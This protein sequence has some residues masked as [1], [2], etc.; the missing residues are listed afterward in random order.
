M[1]EVAFLYQLLKDCA[2]EFLDVDG[3]FP[4]EVHLR[5]SFRAAQPQNEEFFHLLFFGE[6]MPFFR[7]KLFRIAFLHI[8][9]RNFHV[10]PEGGDVL[11]ATILKIG[12]GVEPKT[13][14]T[15]NY[16]YGWKQSLLSHNY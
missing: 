15:S 12:G 8:G 1:D 7:K 5:D 4:Y 10:L 2:V 9:K 14:V 16:S 3:E 11:P 13:E 6:G